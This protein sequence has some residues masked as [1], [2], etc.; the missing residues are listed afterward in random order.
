MN[1]IIH[2]RRGEYFFSTDH[3]QGARG[4]SSYPKGFVPTTFYLPHHVVPRPTCPSGWVETQEDVVKVYHEG[5]REI[6]NPEPR[7]Q[8]AIKSDSL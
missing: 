8:P 5:D 7:F 1:V 3:C 2:S 4:L 6:P